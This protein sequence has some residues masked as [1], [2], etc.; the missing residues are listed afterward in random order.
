MY[1][2][3]LFGLLIILASCKLRDSKNSM[4]VEEVIDTPK[5]VEA[6]REIE[7]NNSPK[8]DKQIICNNEII[9]AEIKS[10]TL[11][12]IKKN[13]SN[14]EIMCRIAP[15]EDG[16]YIDE[17]KFFKYSGDYFF[18]TQI[19]MSGTGFFN[20]DYLFHIDTTNNIL[21]DVEIRYA[22][23]Y[24]SKYL[25]ENEGI[26]KGESRK[27]SDNQITTM[28]Y[29]WKKS[30]ANCCPSVGEVFAKYKIE[31]INDKYIMEQDTCI[32]KMY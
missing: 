9:L 8:S 28:F 24:Y 25:K 14:S 26:W 32:F 22:S 2:I 5:L 21:E 1:K 15:K 19:T 12:L 17:F 31:K 18:K 20:H 30:D 3:I 23:E 7:K 13:D 10:D 29:I 6:P 27:Y 11:F 4:I 16:E